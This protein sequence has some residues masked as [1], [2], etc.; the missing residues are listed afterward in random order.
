M[1]PD[2]AASGNLPSGIH[3][4]VW[5]ELETRY[6]GTPRRRIL[7]QGLRE[8]LKALQAAGCQRAYIDGSFVTEKLNPNDF[9]V[10]WDAT[11]VQ[12]GLLDP[13]LLDMA[14]PRT[15]QKSKF[16]GEFFL[17][18]ARATPRGTLYIDFFQQDKRT[19]DPKGII[20]LDLGGLP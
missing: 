20:E 11:G 9:D 19:G 1:I 5:D 7:L 6:G 13:V 18:N 17:A 16:G 8:G 10:C 14:H 3:S 2:F 12:G 15:G 4:A